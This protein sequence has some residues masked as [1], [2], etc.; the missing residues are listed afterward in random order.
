MSTFRIQHKIAQKGFSLLLGALMSVVILVVAATILNS[1]FKQVV[2]SEVAIESERAFNAAYTGV[3]CARFWNVAD[4]WDPGDNSSDAITCG[5]RSGVSIDDTLPTNS[6]DGTFVSGDEVPAE[7]SRVQFDWASSPNNPHDLSFTHESYRMCTIL[8]VYKY[9]NAS[10]D[11][12][13]SAALPNYSGGPDTTCPA[14]VECTVVHAKGYNRNCG[15]LGSVR[16]V[17]RELTVR[18]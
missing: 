11:S 10:D 15:A 5:D 4:Y 8:Y 2:L 14:G 12:D 17:E 18:F 9:Y 1:T 6:V 16:T 13:M 3:E 7:V